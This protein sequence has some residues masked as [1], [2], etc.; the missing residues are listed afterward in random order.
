MKLTKRIGRFYVPVLTLLL[1]F[2]CA[3]SFLDQPALGSLE[4]SVLDETD[5]A[6]VEKL[7][8]GA[9][10][11]LDGQGDDEALG[12][13]NPWE[14]APDNWIYGAVAGGTASKGSF[15][16]D[17]PA[18]D[19]IAKFS[20]D[21]SNGFFNSKW[22]AL[23]EGVKR[24]NNTLHY[25]NNAPDVSETDRKNITGQARFLRGHYYFELKKMFNMVPWVDE[26]T[27]DPKQPND[28]DIW[29]MI[30][31][32]FQY[33]YENLPATQDE[34]GRANKWAAAAYLGKTYLYQ[35][36]FAEAKD[37]F[38]GV[39]NS[40][41]NSGG[42]KYDLVPLFRD[43]FDAATENN[44]ETVFD[45]QMVA[46]DGTGNITNAN[47]GGKLNFPYNSPFRCCGFYQP[48]QD[49]VN[50]YKTNPDTGLPFL[51][52]YNE[53]PV[54]SDMGINSFDPKDSV[55]TSFDPYEG[56]LDPR[57]DWTVGRRGVPY[58]DWG[59]HPGKKWIRD[60]SYGGPYAPKKNIYWQATQNQYAD[61]S[62]WAPGTAINVH[63]IR[64]ADVLLMAAE[65]EAQA[66]SL[67]TAMEYVNRVRRRAADPDG[68]L[69]EY[70]D[71]SD[72]MDG[73][74]AST[75]AANYTIEEYTAAQFS[76]K[77][78]ALKAIYFERKL[79]LAM[80]GHRFFDLVRWGI[81]E[82]TLNAYFEYQGGITTD[83][84]GGRFIPGKSEYYP[85]PQAQIDLS[86]N[87]TGQ[88][89]LQQNPGY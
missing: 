11:A 60:Q 43:N 87:E 2:S 38:A 72:P 14:A 15:G 71:E 41:V 78:D 84:R 31:A 47:Q 80:E 51:D 19:P 81:A 10:A 64:F 63:I 48:T 25:L 22:K 68:F 17:Q 8:I 5:Q 16:G 67:S 86:V 77:E 34:F 52:N 33:A 42:V 85:I 44:A 45:I 61:Q 6:G 49:L 7:L 21:P 76:A 23:F 37:M 83:V 24:C 65:A 13:G 62:S 3:D 66:G 57:L 28:Q 75:D 55:N 18:I 69:K 82:E 59:K 89:T 70:I 26:T 46:N 29:P 35:Q 36:K 50:S 12:G 4:D 79:E 1:L 56:E 88:P 54:K 73:F 9:Y 40:G 39:I 58:H 20:S 30:E 74:D 32:D 53:N 27:E